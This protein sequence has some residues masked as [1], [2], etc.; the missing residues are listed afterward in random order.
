MRA[1]VQRVTEASVTS[2]G[3]PA[4]RIG[5]G[6]CVLLGVE[7]GDTEKDAVYMAGKLAKLRVFED[8]NEK[9]NLSVLDTGGSILCVSQFTLLGDARGQN[10]PG[11]TR[12]E[13]PERADALYE[14]VC[15]ELRA[16]GLTVETGVFRTHMQVSLINDGPV[17]ILLDSRKTF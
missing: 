11:F 2:Q 3:T 13:R 17:T 1:V 14:Q 5:K 12:A 8:E 10:R 7:E 16:L 4:G 15:R 6:L 9:M